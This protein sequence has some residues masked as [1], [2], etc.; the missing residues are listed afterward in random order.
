VGCD[1]EGIILK[2][3][4]NEYNGTAKN[5][6]WA[7][8]CILEHNCVIFVFKSQSFLFPTTCVYVV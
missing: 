7:G 8:F 6:N 4:K 5:G 1:E 3:E 2:L